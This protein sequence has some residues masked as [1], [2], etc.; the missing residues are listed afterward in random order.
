MMGR[1][2]TYR[3]YRPQGRSE[4]TAL[5]LKGIAADQLEQLRRQLEPNLGAEQRQAWRGRSPLAGSR[6]VME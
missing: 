1:N 2:Q 5:E 6:N 4:A 3:I